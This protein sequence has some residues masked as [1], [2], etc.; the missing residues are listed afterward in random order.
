MPTFSCDGC[1]QG[2]L[3]QPPDD[4]HTEANRQYDSLQKPVKTSFKC[5]NKDCGRL[6]FVYWYKPKPLI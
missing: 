3:I 6:N 4:I 2:K 1:G 5:E